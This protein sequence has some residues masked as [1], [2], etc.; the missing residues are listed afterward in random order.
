MGA[1]THMGLIVSAGAAGCPPFFLGVP[2]CEVHT[3]ASF[4]GSGGWCYG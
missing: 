4:G 1:W 2:I 3:L